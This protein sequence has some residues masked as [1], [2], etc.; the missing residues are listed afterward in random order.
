MVRAFELHFWQ[1][2][3][4]NWAKD[5]TFLAKPFKTTWNTRLAIEKS[6][7]N[8]LPEICSKVMM[9]LTNKD[10]SNSIN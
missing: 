6:K 4:K 10:K 8:I 7:K 2:L 5:Q 1:W 3:K 9:L